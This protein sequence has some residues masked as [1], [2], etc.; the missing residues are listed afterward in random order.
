MI[1][2]TERQA[3]SRKSPAQLR[4]EINEIVA[5]SPSRPKSAVVIV[6]GRPSG[7]WYAQAHDPKT[8]VRITDAS[9]Y[10]RDGALR[11]LRGKFAMIGVTIE[12]ITDQ[13][14]Y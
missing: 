12:S 6:Y 3:K 5:R 9:G 7:Y 14:P 4:H 13:D 2:R 8:G 1:R 11:E 10:S